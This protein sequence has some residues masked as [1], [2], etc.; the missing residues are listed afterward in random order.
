VV[1]TVLDNHRH[2][3]NGTFARPVG[4]SA[5]STLLTHEAPS[6]VLA[7]GGDRYGI[8]GIAPRACARLGSTRDSEDSHIAFCFARAICPSDVCRCALGYYAGAAGEKFTDSLVAGFAGREEKLMSKDAVQPVLVDDR[9]RWRALIVLCL[10]VLMIMVDTTIVNVALPSIRQDLHFTETSLAWVVNSYMLTF[11]GTL[12]LGGRLGDVYGQRKLFLIGIALFTIASLGCG[13]AA[14]PVMLVGARTL[15]GLGGA[16]VAAV[17]LSLMMGMFTT[18]TERAKAMAVYG[19]ISYGGA[20]IGLLLGGALMS[21]LQ[22]PWVFLVNLP[23]GV[24]VYLLSLSLLPHRRVEPSSGALDIWGAVTVTSSLML[25]MYLVSNVTAAGWTSVQTLALMACVAALLAAF[26]MVERRVPRP[27]MPPSIFT[28]NL[29]ILCVVAVLWATGVRAWSFISP[30]YMQL[31]LGSRP[32]Q[33][34][35]AFLAST[36]ISAAFSLGLSAR[37]VSRFGIKIPLGAGMLLGAAGLALLAHAPVQGSV[38]I[39]VV[40]SMAL[41][42]L[43]TGIVFSPLLIAAMSN[44]APSESGLVSGIINTASLMGG[45]LGLA[46]L[47]SLCAARTNHLLALGASTPVALTGGYHLALLAGVVCASAAALLGTALL[48]TKI[49]HSPEPVKLDAAVTSEGD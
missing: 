47:A 22:W 42:G 49:L 28:R 23:V 11:G 38:L 33:I 29:S 45:A 32:A 39:D 40:P 17:A 43:G 48:R 19:F 13:L 3:Q 9:R 15:Q 1:A 7:R 12:L 14:T 34:A 25:A 27:L 46:V 37:L 20:S 31:V 18:R 35:A 26:F 8:I 4:S 16:I 21:G 24:A 36:V 6:P 30:L 10:G 44:V 41:L 2:L 5:A